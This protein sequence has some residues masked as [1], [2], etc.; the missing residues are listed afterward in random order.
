VL[1][2]R[3]ASVAASLA[4]VLAFSS[5]TASARSIINY[6][7]RETV[8]AL[9]PDG[10]Y[11]AE[12]MG[13]SSGWTIIG[14]AASHIYGGSAGLFAIDPTT[15]DI[16]E[17]DGTPGSWTTIGGPGWE[18]VQSDGHLYG[19]GVGGGYVAEWNGTPNSWTIIG[20][21]AGNIYGGGYGLI[22]TSPGTGYTGNVWY[23]DGTPNSWTDIGSSGDDFAVGTDAVYRESY[24]YLS[25]SQW[26]GGTTWTPIGPANAQG[27]SIDAAGPE[28][29][30]ITDVSNNQEELRYDGTPGNWTEVGNFSV[31]ADVGAESMTSVYGTEIDQSTGDTI[32]GVYLWSGSGENWTQIGGPAGWPL[33]AEN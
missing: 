24:D 31:G 10:S 15:G 21:A 1:Y 12:W 5:T 9:A 17:Y 11:V 30:F 20:G 32:A 19:L 8:Y 14:G 33:A 4:A 22:A 25:I 29:L 28:G 23:Y 27:L 18:F 6:W 13:L 2:K 16:S 3:T 7:P 26:T